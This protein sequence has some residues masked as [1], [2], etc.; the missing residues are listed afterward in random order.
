MVS[1]P[2]SPHLASPA[3]LQERIAVERTGESFVVYR[4]GAGG[5]RIEPLGEAEVV[6]IGRGCE[7]EV[8]LDWDSQVSRLH[9][10]LRRV[11]GQWLV[12]DD[13]LSRNGTFVNGQ[14]VRGRRRLSDGDEVRVSETILVFREGQTRGSS[15]VV[16]SQAGAV[17][18]LS[19][20]QRRVLVALCRPYRFEGGSG[21]PATNQQIARELFV[22]VGTVKGH[23]RAL[24]QRFGLEDVPQNE[25]RTRLARLAL[26]TG[27]VSLSGAEQEP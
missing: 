21:R 1:S 14:R 2:L 15:T 10:E 12:L 9:A 18:E 5:Q 25:K 6:L 26:D 11:G 17:P 22:T 4:D 8:S 23:L 24:C 19:P 27:A 20:A 16:L 3:E 7:C 13:G